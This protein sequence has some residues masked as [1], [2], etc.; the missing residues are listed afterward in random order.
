MDEAHMGAEGVVALARST[1]YALDCNRCPGHYCEMGQKPL[2][3]IP[4]QQI[5]I[6]SQNNEV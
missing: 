5:T 6:N 3:D 2:E 4:C 1:F